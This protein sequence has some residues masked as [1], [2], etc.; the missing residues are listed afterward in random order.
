TVSLDKPARLDLGGIAK[1]YA[2]DL[3]IAALKQAGATSGLINAGGD[4]RAFGDAAWPVTV[5]DPA[6]RQ[7]LVQVELRRAA[8]ATSAGLRGGTA[9][10]F[11]HLAKAA[12]RWTSVTVRAP[13]ACDADALTKIVWALG[14]CAAGLVSEAGAAAFAIRS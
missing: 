14:H 5:V 2:V 1:G 10:S 13:D 7:G 3:A 4:L 11:E 9:L 12:P 6:T 8:L